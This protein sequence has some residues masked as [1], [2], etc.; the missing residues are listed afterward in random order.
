MLK[1][2]F[3]IWLLL[4][5]AFGGI[6]LQLLID[7]GVVTG[8]VNAEVVE[9]MINRCSSINDGGPF[10]NDLHCNEPRSAL[11]IINK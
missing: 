3:T 11:K 8:V 9:G 10:D 7:I 2:G 4:K 5:L 6:I 1:C